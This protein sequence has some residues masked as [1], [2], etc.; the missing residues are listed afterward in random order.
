MF[1]QYSSYLCYAETRKY[2]QIY[3]LIRNRQCDFDS[4]YY[5]WITARLLYIHIH[6]RDSVL[7]KF[8]EI[9]KWSC[10]L[11]DL[12][13]GFIFKTHRFRFIHKYFNKSSF[14]R[15]YTHESLYFLDR[16]AKKYF[17]I[18]SDVVRTA[19]AKLKSLFSLLLY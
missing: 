17:R 8:R 13:T 2:M 19:Q 14:I 15:F 10:C 18:V 9:W 5:S 1:G 4:G 11:S 3:S 16:T 12:K 7:G 6:S